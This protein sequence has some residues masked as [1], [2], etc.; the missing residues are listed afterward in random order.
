MKLC[1]MLDNKT[2]QIIK[3]PEVHYG[4]YAIELV[5][6]YGEH[7]NYE[8]FEEKSGKKQVYS[9]GVIEYQANDGSTCGRLGMIN[10]MLKSLE[11]RDYRSLSEKMCSYIENEQTSKDLF[12]IL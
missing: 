2:A 4:V 8:F 7:I 12:E 6:F 5:V 3:I 11:D 1:C 10:G 9:R